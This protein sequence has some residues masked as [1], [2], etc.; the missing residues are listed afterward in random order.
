MAASRRA[1][2][3]GTL[4]KNSRGYWVGGVELPPGPDGKRRQKR[5]VRKSRNDCM[6]ALRKLRSEVEAGSVATSGKTTVSAWLDFWAEKI[7]P[8]KD[9][10]PSTLYQY[11]AAVRLYL[12][13]TLGG[14]RL[15]KLTPADVRAMHATVVKR[16][17]GRSAQ[18]ADRVLRLALK[19]AVREGVL[20]HAVTDRIDPPAHRA[21]EGTAFG[22][23]VAAHIIATAV[24]VQGVMWG[25]RWATGFLTGARESEI[26]GLEWDRVDLQ[27]GVMDISWQLNRQQ[28]RHG[29]GEPV[30]G[31]HPC[32]K[33]RSSFCPKAEWDFPPGL[34]WRPCAGTLVWTTPKT[35]AGRRLIPIVPT[36]AEILRQLDRDGPL[37]FHINGKP[38]SQEVDQRGWKA[39]LVAAG[40]PHAKQH[41]IRHSTATLLLEAGVDAHIVQSVIGHTDIATTRGYQH[42]NL[43]M[44][45]AA[46]DNLGALMPVTK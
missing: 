35:K 42:V 3:D 41:S 6:E 44:A 23:A 45:R 5:I 2:H 24:E 29:C 38:I 11:R 30:D 1:P 37:V 36:L 10:K 12:K 16:A 34:E 39:L 43:D 21:Q 13:P 28:K 40:I 25:A 46:W 17:G 27:R 31:I 20:A 18:K 32:G 26:L 4:F 7:L 9:L 8:A 15:A 19:A 22:S 14:K 33:V